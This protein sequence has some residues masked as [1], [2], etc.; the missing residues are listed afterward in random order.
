MTMQTAGIFTFD[1]SAQQ[2]NRIAM[3]AELRNLLTATIPG[4]DGYPVPMVVDPLRSQ[5][6]DALRDVLGIASDTDSPA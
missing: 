3:V 4:E 1:D 2:R 5:V 6:V